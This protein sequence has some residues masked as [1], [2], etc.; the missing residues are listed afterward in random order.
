MGQDDKVEPRQVH[1]LGF[2]I[3]AQDVRVIAGVKQNT[4]AA[5]LDKRGESPVFL[6]RR[7]LA[8][9]IIQ[10]RY[11]RLRWF[12]ACRPRRQQRGVSSQQQPQ[13]RS[14]EHDAS[15]GFHL[16]P[17]RAEVSIGGGISAGASTQLI[18][19]GTGPDRADRTVL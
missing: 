19:R 2:G 3:A 1:A 6:H 13:R 17:P 4:L 5:I 16:L 15:L 8:E 12:G 11:L 7:R 9:G 10:N 14:A 18:A